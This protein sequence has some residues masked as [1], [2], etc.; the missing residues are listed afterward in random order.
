[1]PHSE[2]I[3]L[4][5]NSNG[6]M[7]LLHKETMRFV[8]VGVQT[9]LAP[10]VSSLLFLLIFAYLLEGKIEPH[11]GMGYTAFLIPG[12]IMM[13]LQQNAFAN[14]SSSLTQSKITGNLVFLMLSPMRPWEWFVGYIGGAVLR[15]VFCGLGVW[16][17]ALFFIPLAIHSIWWTFTFALLACIILGT[18]G[19]IAG[20]WAEKW[21]HVSAFQNFL[22][23]PL[24]FLAGVF[25][26]V[27]QLPPVW[28]AISHLNP[29]F[30]LIDGFRF[31]MYGV[32]DVSPWLS[33][34]ISGTAATLLT[35]LT[36][37][38]IQ[39]GWRLRS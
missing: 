16:V 8:K 39:K 4:A 38:L 19:F 31:G 22:I 33:L 7:A 24:T 20:L 21:D 2:V 36:L 23:N 26:S 37:R 17:V 3:A 29:F 12:L 11:P 13:T 27:H 32:A 15:G 6:A 18:L 28:Q 34:S 14:A 5:P 25:Y 9:I 1:M 10:V 35:L 30:Y